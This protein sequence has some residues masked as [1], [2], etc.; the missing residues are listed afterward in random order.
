MYETLNGSA[1]PLASK[2]MQVVAIPDDER[3]WISSGGGRRLQVM[4][5]IG[6]DDPAHLASRAVVEVADEVRTPVARAEHRDADRRGVAHR[7]IPSPTST[8][9]RRMDHQ[10]RPGAIF[11]W[12]RARGG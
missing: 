5:P 4:E 7:R 2:E 11:V 10:P 12:P 6:H 3:V 1:H 9:G 8:S